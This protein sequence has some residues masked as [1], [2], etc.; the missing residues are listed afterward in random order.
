VV[1][2]HA[3]V[4]KEATTSDDVI[5]SSSPCHYGATVVDT[6]V[7]ALV[8]MEAGS[9]INL[10]APVQCVVGNAIFA[11]LPAKVVNVTIERIGLSRLELEAK[12]VLDL[13]LENVEAHAT[14]RVLQASV[15]STAQRGRWV[16]RA[17]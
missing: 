10:V 3:L 17:N 12:E 14:D 8:N 1:V 11:S 9:R 7:V 2:F 13:C 6:G 16:G 4:S 5:V 15:L